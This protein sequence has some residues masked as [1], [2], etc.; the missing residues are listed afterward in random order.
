MDAEMEAM[1]I[2]MAEMTKL[3]N[4]LQQSGLRGRGR[5]RGK[6]GP[7]NIRGGLA[8]G[9][10]RGAICHLLKTHVVLKNYLYTTPHIDQGFPIGSL[11]YLTIVSLIYNERACSEIYE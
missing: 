4:G 3:V 7:A 10:G 2:Q 5:G 1:K 8:A 9:G 6:G 11:L